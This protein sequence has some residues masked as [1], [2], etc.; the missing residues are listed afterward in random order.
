M[1]GLVLYNGL[2]SS[3][4][5]PKSGHRGWNNGAFAHYASSND[6][7][8]GWNN[9]AFAHYASSN[10]SPRR[11][12]FLFFVTNTPQSF[13]AKAANTHQLSVATASSHLRTPFSGVG[14]ALLSSFITKE[15]T[16]S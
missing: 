2:I 16:H 7:H 1:F 11:P 10:D 5:L 3:T 14:S 13:T 8:R 15:Y 9:G 12:N 4:N 6:S